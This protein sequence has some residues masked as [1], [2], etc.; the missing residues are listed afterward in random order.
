MFSTP[1]VKSRRID[2]IRPQG[3]SFEKVYS[4]QTEA[5]KKSAWIHSLNNT[6]FK[7][8]VVFNIFYYILF[9]YIYIC[10]CIYFLIYMYIFYIF[11]Y[12]YI[13]YCG[14][15]YIYCIITLFIYIYCKNNNIYIYICMYAVLGHFGN[16]YCFKCCARKHFQIVFTHY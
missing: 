13:Y 14:Y 10:T 12:I 9:I 8:P 15:I 7:Y 11:I 2:Y 4:S 5:S 1:A 3:L 16:N 6:I